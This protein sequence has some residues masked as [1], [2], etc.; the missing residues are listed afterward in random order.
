MVNSTVPAHLERVLNKLKGVRP[1][2]DGWVA[3]CPCPDHNQDG[4]QNPSLGIA[5]GEDGHVLINCRV[6]CITDA[7]LEAAGLEWSDVS[8]PEDSAEAISA[9]S[10][11]VTTPVTPEKA[12]ADLCHRAYESL[13]AQ[14]TLSDDHRLDLQRRGLSNAEIDCRGYRSVRNVDR[15]KAATAVHEQLGDAVLGVPGFVRG[16]YCV[17]LQGDAPGL[18]VPV[19]DAQGRIQALKIRRATAPK[20][21][22]L[23]SAELGPSPGSPVHIPM[24]VTAPAPVVRVTEGELKADVC[25]ALDDTPTIGV[26]GVAQW[27]G[28]ISVLKALGARTI[29]IAFDAPDVHTKSPVFE[30]TEMFW[31]ALMNENFDVELEDWYEPVQGS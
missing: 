23:T 31:Q 16:E 29:V 1:T 3:L 18:L 11:A 27:R 24:G 10:T 5:L 25:T 9:V 28:A 14:L 15:G 13:L 4:D 6:G 26:P 20:Y 8:P 2:H 21:V 30:Q 22:Y 17:T 19:R 12:D 7:V